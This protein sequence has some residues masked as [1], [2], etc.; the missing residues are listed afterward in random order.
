M[1]IATFNVNGIRARLPIVVE[2]LD[3]ERPN[4][5][6]LQE[7]KVRDKDFP[8][9]PFDHLGYHYVLRGQKAYNGVAI[10]SQQKPE[11]VRFGFGDDEAAE[12]PRLVSATIEGVVVV[13]SYVPNGATPE[14]EKFAYKI[15]WLKRLRTYFE[16]WFSP[17]SRLLWVGDFNVAPETIDV[18]D[19]ERLRGHIGFHPDEHK[20]LAA[21]KAWGFVDIFRK[22]VRDE[23]M[24]SFW[25]YRVKNAVSR[26]LGWRLDHI[27]ATKAMAGTSTRAW[28]DLR[29][30]LLPRP[31]DHTLVVAEFDVLRNHTFSGHKRLPRCL[32]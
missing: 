17:E 24:Y 4:I 3:R 27:W 30:R 21:V 13:N 26:G 7:T 19:P 12:E 32:I 25:D 11:I 2:W 29:P 22:H 5:L 10:I 6:C 9:E 18:Y 31:S 8:V 14:S 15:R 1:K 23:K 28:I 16:Q 20:A